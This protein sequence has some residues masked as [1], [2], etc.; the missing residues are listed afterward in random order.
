MTR[1][2][3]REIERTVEKLSGTPGSATLAELLRAD[4]VVTTGKRDKETPI[5]CVDGVEKH[6]PKRVRG[7][8]I[9]LTLGGDPK[10]HNPPEEALADFREGCS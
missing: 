7:D 9:R 4:D 10:N 6:I 8:F 3:K 2:S 5:W 1:S